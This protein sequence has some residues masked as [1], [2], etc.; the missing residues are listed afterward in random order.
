MPQFF[1]LVVAKHTPQGYITQ[2]GVA[3]G[4]S[5]CQGNLVEGISGGGNTVNCCPKQ[6]GMDCPLGNSLHDVGDPK[7]TSELFRHPTIEWGSPK[8]KTMMAKIGSTD[9]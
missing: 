4:G 3:T 8:D 9:N 7:K 1:A 6:G 2:G 5:R